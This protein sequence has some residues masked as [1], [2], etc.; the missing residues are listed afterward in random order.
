[1]AE[2]QA[3]TGKVP[4]APSEEAAPPPAPAEAVKD[5]A[6]EK[7]VIPSEEKPDDSKALAVVEKVADP[8]ATEKTGGSLDRDAVLTRVET[9][10]KLSLIKAWEENEK[11]KAENKAQKKLSNITS[12]EN[13][14][15]AD[16]EAQLKKIEES[17]E[18]KKAV[19]AEKMKNRVATVHK[20]AEEK[21]A[22]V[23]AQ[24]GEELLKAEEMAAKYR[25]KGL[26][27]K[28]VLGCFGS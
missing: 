23:E 9:E 16:L 17:L 19:Y 10:K 18:N 13:T 12:W 22:M 27:P 26:V 15:K 11:S 1:M 24:K 21:R 2:A 14:K 7:A 6:E 4:A 25:I 5:V 8:P 3:E 20:V 28:K